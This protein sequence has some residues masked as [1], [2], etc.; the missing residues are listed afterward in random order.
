VNLPFA[1]LVEGAIIGAVVG[2]AVALISMLFRTGK[3]CPECKQPLP[4]PWA[5]PVKQCPKC[6]CRLNAKGE[7]IGDGKD[8]Y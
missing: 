5:S 4:I 3:P 2:A 8:A 7:K 1:G 6:G